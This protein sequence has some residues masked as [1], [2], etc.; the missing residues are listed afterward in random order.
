MKDILFTITESKHIVLEVKE[1]SRYILLPHLNKDH[2]EVT[3]E[4]NF[5]AP[6]V[7]TELLCLYKLTEGQSFHLSTVTNHNVSNTSCFTDV[8]GILG[9]KA[10]SKFFGKIKIASQGHGTNSFL[11]HKVLVLGESTSNISEPTL[12]IDANDVKAS[13]GSTTGRIN[14]D[15]LYYLRSRGLSVKECEE[16]ISNGFLGSLISKIEDKEI[17]NE[18]FSAIMHQ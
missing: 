12:E 18:V 1:P 8:R 11:S 17:R 13:H 2:C 16:L 10:T 4:L 7:A 14:K 15:Q 6:G 3:F 9:D 5:N